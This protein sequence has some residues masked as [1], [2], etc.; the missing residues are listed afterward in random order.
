MQVRAQ[1]QVH[2]QTHVHVQM[3][4]QTTQILLNACKQQ[5]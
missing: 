1:M 5:I 3:Q 2:A 4:V